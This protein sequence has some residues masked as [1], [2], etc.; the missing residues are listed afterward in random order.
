M[1][2]D[3]VEEFN[4]YISQPLYLRGVDAVCFAF[5]VTQN[6]TS[7]YKANLFFDDQTSL[8]GIVG[9]GIPN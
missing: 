3:T 6:S 2:F 7:S 1:Y 4:T 8:G 5:M 9:T